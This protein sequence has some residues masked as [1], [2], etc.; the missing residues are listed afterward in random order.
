MAWGSVS[1][2]GTPIA[3]RVVKEVRIEGLLIQ[4]I[5]NLIYLIP[6]WVIVS[7]HHDW[8][9]AHLVSMGVGYSWNTGYITMQP[10]PIQL[11]NLVDW[12]YVIEGAVD[13][14]NFLLFFL[15]FTVQC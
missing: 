8:F 9:W 13:N 5:P 1:V 3:Y 6:I 7:P 12:F 11:T 4:G 14:L 15:C 2:F 10:D